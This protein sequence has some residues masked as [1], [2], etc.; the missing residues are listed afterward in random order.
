MPPANLR[1]LRTEAH[2]F[3]QRSCYF[4]TSFCDGRAILTMPAI[5]ASRCLLYLHV[6]HVFC[7]RKVQIF[8]KHFQGIAGLCA[9]PKIY[10][11]RNV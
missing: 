9:P 5:Q 10:R 2:A 11:L 3:A 1:H 4:E 8:F 7:R 6:I